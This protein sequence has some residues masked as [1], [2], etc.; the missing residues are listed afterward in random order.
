MTTTSETSACGAS[1]ITPQDAKVPQLVSMEE[2]A[3]REEVN[4]E[5]NEEDILKRPED[6]TIAVVMATSNSST[7]SASAITS[8][9][10]TDEEDIDEKPRDIATAK[11]E[12]GTSDA[13][14]EVSDEDEENQKERLR[15]KWRDIRKRKKE[16]L[17]ETVGDKYELKIEN[18][19]LKK[20]YK[21]LKVLHRR[22]SAIVKILENGMNSSSSGLAFAHNPNL[23]MAY[24]TAK[25]ILLNNG[26]LHVPV[27]K[28]ASQVLVQA[29]QGQ[30]LS[31]VLTNS[32]LLVHQQNQHLLNLAATT[33]FPVGTVAP[34]V[35][36]SG[37]CL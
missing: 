13:N 19:R 32:P 28:H 31:P 5:S 27:Q 18:D 34:G 8:K 24:P 17:A 20:E 9:T 10:E 2:E 15:Q 35:A 22:A 12:A 7:C 4:S 23:H 37:H 30:L 16:W 1:T 21:R 33:A 14:K 11:E 3:K 26:L 6:L 25:P 29:N 36:C